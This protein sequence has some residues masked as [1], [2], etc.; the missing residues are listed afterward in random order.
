MKRLIIVY[1]VAGLA[2]AASSA[3]ANLTNEGFES[4]DL[5]GWLAWPDLLVSVL[6]SA[7]GLGN[8]ANT[9]WLP[10]EGNYFA[11]LKTGGG[12]GVYTTMTQSFTTQ[13]GYD[14]SFDIFFDTADYSPFNDDG[15]AKLVGFAGAPTTT[16]YAQSVSTVG[17]KNADGWT[18]ISFTI[19]QT[20]IYALEFG[21]E[22]IGD[23][24]VLS[25]I[26]VDNIVIPSPS[27]VF[28]GSFGVGLVGWLRRRRTL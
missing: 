1:L 9:T 28:I 23:D 26:G 25:A 2:F 8:Q 5:T 18:H 22:N 20:G 11:Y 12:E 21:V 14:L 13:A 3:R 4:G 24:I 6:N 10:T 27:A 19:P 16:L 7:K 15:Y 17:D